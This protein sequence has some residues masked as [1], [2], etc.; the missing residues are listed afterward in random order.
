MNEKEDRIR[1]FAQ[2][3][4]VGSREEKP[5]SQ[6]LEEARQICDSDALRGLS[7]TDESDLSNI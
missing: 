3:L 4:W 7:R 2:A 6:C 5:M 1:R